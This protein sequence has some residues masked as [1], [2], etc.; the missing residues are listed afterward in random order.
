ML[1]D[2]F[3]QLFGRFSDVLN[4]F[5]KKKQNKTKQ[6]TN[7]QKTSKQTNKKKQIEK[8]DLTPFARFLR[9]KVLK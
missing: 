7:K 4:I 5:E 6:Q 3:R 8:S 9:R 2:K 1:H